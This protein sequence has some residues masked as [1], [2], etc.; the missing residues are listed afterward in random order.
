MPIESINSPLKDISRLNIV[1]FPGWSFNAEVFSILQKEI[2]A[3]LKTRQPHI[4]LCHY[5]YRWPSDMIDFHSAVLNELDN[6]PVDSILI[7]WSLG[8]AV[9]KSIFQKNDNAIKLIILCSDQTFLYTEELP[10]GMKKHIFEAFKF[11]M[12]VTPKKTLSRFIHLC[13]HGSS[14]SNVNSLFKLLQSHQRTDLST[15]KHQDLLINQLEWLSQ[16]E[17]NHKDENEVSIKANNDYL[18]QRPISLSYSF[19]YIIENSSHA[20]FIENPNHIS[21]IIVQELCSSIRKLN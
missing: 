7:G 15:Q 6:I 16:F 4:Q 9:A 12:Q 5:F 11:S 3:K 1:W 13:L 19:D 18:F 20:T 14:S 2:E 21:K 10:Y 17:F 8:G